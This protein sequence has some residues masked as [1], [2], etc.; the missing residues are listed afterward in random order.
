MSSTLEPYPLCDDVRLQA[1]EL[2]GSVSGLDGVVVR[3]LG[4]LLHAASVPDR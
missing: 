1:I 2:G 3:G 4:W